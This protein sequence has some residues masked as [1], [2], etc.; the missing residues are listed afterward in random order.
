MT[1][2]RD[3]GFVQSDSRGPQLPACA[4]NRPRRGI[5]P[6]PRRRAEAPVMIT[7]NHLVA[8]PRTPARQDAQAARRYPRLD[9][10]I[11]GIF[12]GPIPISMLWCARFSLPGGRQKA[13]PCDPR[14]PHSVS[15]HAKS[16]SAPSPC[17]RFTPAANGHHRLDRPC[18]FCANNVGH[19]SAARPATFVDH[20]GSMG[21]R[22]FQVHEHGNALAGPRG[23]GSLVGS[24]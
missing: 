1:G 14:A 8:R 13:P 15:I 6:R 2:S 10:G 3:R 22:R 16:I 17:V 24:R 9:R 11:F 5:G 21:A 18:P 12:D 4:S 7:S 19:V 20:L 23:S